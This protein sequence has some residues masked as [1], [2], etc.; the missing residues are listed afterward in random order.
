MVCPECGSNEGTK[1][2]EVAHTEDSTV[3]KRSCK[4]CG[5]IFKTEELVNPYVAVPNRRAQYRKTKLE[6]SEHGLEDFLNG[7]FKQR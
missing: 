3:R 1:V 4:H 2:I 6:N 5:A 7:F